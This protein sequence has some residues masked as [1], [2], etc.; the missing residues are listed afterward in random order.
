MS[1]LY[2]NES[3]KAFVSL[4][5]GEG[6]GLPLLES[7]AAGLPVIATNW[8]AHTE[9]LS[10]GRFISID[11]DLIDVPK[12][13]IDGRI[14]VDGIKWADPHEEDFKKKILKFKQK[15]DIP[16]EWASDLSE[17]IRDKYSSFRIADH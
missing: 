7:A 12:S 11:Y 16:T 3:I 5:R 9:F 2:S 4:T 14:F 10:M 15:P 1:G 6:F 8:S 17:K 13:K